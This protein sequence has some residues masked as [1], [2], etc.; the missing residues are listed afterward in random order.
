M[1]LL[2]LLLVEEED[3]DDDDDIVILNDGQKS[4]FYIRSFISFAR[5]H[6]DTDKSRQTGRQAGTVVVF[7]LAQAICIASL[8]ETSFKSG[9]VGEKN[10]EKRRPST[11]KKL[12]PL[13][14][15]DL[16]LLPPMS[17][18]PP[19]SLSFKML[20]VGDSFFFSFLKIIMCINISNIGRWGRF[21]Y[22]TRQDEEEEEPLGK[23]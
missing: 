6:T 16:S 18:P 1:L 7:S 3:D 19:P 9:G 14:V 5:Q 17:L 10:K 4:H 11:T 22:S 2:L 12:K 20:V 8:R 13:V 15:G 21:C 23:G